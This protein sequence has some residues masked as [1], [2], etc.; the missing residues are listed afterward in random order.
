MNEVKSINCGGKIVDLRK[1]IVMGILN[2]T[3]DSFFDGGKFMN[4]NACL[5]QASLM[6]EEGADIIDIGGYSSRPGA[7]E[8]SVQE[9]LDRVIPA[10]EK[11][12]T[13]LETIISID[14][15]RSEVAG[16][17]LD[18]GAT[19]VNDISA[20]DDD[21]MMFDLI[22]ER[23]VPYVIMHKQG[24]PK[25]MQDNPQYENVLAEVYNYLYEKV[26]LL[27]SKGIPDIIIDPGFGFGKTVEH[28][29]ELL[30]G[31]ESLRTIGVPILAGLSRKSM[32]QK[33]LDLNAENALNGTTVLNT[34]AI[35]NGAK[36]LRVHDVKEAVEVVTLLSQ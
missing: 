33:V 17:A 35:T 30:H 21:P 11:L 25:T 1:P 23:K 15:F 31:L 36:I 26:L 9:E 5:S 4:I 3:S 6:V 27:K 29:Y 32:I 12:K 34:M 20:G 22:E 18:A 8:I 16:K 7:A 14:T 13:E 10:I 19:M 28:N 2:V 24:R